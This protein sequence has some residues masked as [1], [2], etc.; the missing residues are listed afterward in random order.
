MFPNNSTQL[1]LQTGTVAGTLTLVPTFITDGGINLTPATPPSLNL[2]VAQSAPR[3]LSVQL[4]SKTSNALTL[5]ITGYATGRAH[6]GNRHPIYAGSGRKCGYD[7]AELARRTRAFTA[8]FQSAQSQ[9]FGSQ[10]TVTLPLSLEG[11]LVNVTTLTG[12]IQSAS[13]TLTNNQGVSNS[14][15]VSLQ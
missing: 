1:R 5:L 4:S 3:L 13:V 15:S 9:Q 8:W 11:D 7:K 10:F 2:T 12:A 6:H 14:Q